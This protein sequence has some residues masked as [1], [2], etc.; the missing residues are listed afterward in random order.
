MMG[1]LEDLLLTPQP[2]PGDHRD[3]IAMVHRN[4]LR[5]LKLVNTLLDFSRIEAGRVRAHFEPVDLCTLTADLAS[6]FRSAME[7]AGLAFDVSSACR[8]ARPVYVDRDMWEKIVLNLISNAFKFTLHGRVAVSVGAAIGPCPGG[9]RGHGHRHSAGPAAARIRPLSP[10]RRLAGTQPRGIG[11]RT[12]PGPRTGQAARRRIER[13]ERDRSR[14]HLHRLHSHRLGAPAR[15]PDL[16]RRP[17]HR[18]CAPP[19]RTRKKR[20]DGCRRSAGDSEHPDAE[21]A[22]G[23]RRTRQVPG[24][25]SLPTTTRT[26]ATTRNACCRSAGAWRRSA[27]APRRWPPRARRDP[28]SSSPTS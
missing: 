17:Q 25:C 7:R 28:T 24:T 15:R 16:C 4:A 14:Q 3:A 10:G 13:R 5:L 1:P 27:T 21:A 19:R 9:R 6:T 18:S 20:C 26:C 2:L 8:L 23:E 11:H 12:R 22:H